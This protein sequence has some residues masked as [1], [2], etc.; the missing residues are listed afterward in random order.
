MDKRHL[1]LHR[2]CQLVVAP[3]E[4]LF[5]GVAWGR[6]GQGIIA[7]AT[8]SSVEDVLSQLRATLDA[9]VT[10]ESLRAA[11]LQKHAQFLRSRGI[12]PDGLSLV[13]LTSAAHALRRTAV[14]WNCHAALD[15]ASDLECTGCKWI[16]CTA[17]GACGHG[18]P[19]HGEKF[20]SRPR[21]STADF[22]EVHFEKFTDAQRFARS[23]PGSKV[24]KGSSGTGRAVQ[25]P[26]RNDDA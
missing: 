2:G 16:I 20:Q 3:K 26:T 21:A 14:C 1:D 12:D 6:A 17:C 19:I 24:T 25:T 11:M 15:N 7:R 8:G 13:R 9:P 23:C 5:H 4:G 10:K 18:H 22:T